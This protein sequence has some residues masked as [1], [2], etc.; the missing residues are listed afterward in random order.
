[1]GNKYLDIRYN[2]GMSKLSK[3][4]PAIAVFVISIIPLV[5]L[6]FSGFPIT[7][8]GQDH[9]A[10]IANFYR[11]LA[12]GNIIPRWASNLNWGY[13]H[14]ILMFLYPFPSYIA[15]FFHFL[16]L[17]FVDS[18]KSVFIVA[19][20]ASG[21][22]MYVWM[23]AVFGK[24]AGI[25]GSILY[26]FAPY[27]FVDLYVRGAIGEHVAFIFPPLI[28]YFLFK[29][30][31]KE[32]NSL[33]GIGLS[34]SL[35]CFILSH[36]A[37]S[38]MFLPVIVL[39]AFYLF[40]T[41][42]KRSMRF[43]LSASYSILLGFGLSAFF[44]FPAFF[45]GKYT[46]RDI[47]TAGEAMQRFVPPMMFFYSPWNYGG[48]NEI[49]KMIGFAQ[50][51]GIIASVGIFIKTRETK[52]KILIGGLFVLFIGS[53]LMMTK[54]SN[55]LWTNITLLQKFQFPWR[56][57]SLSVFLV[58]VLGGVAIAALKMKSK[59]L[60]LVPLGI[61]CIYAVISTAHMWK[62]IGYQNKDESFYTG[63]YLST[64]DTGE[65]SP[66]WSTRFMEHV[67][68]DPLVLIDGSAQIRKTLRTTTVHEYEIIAKKPSR[69]VENTVYFPGWNVYIDERKAEVE[70]QDPNYRGLLTF[71]V[72]EGN[73]AVR[74]QFQD[75][76]LRFI[77]NIISIV[78]LVTL[79]LLRRKV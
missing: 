72:P 69:L 55:V 45:E 74:V 36:N 75:T 15:S 37:I 54:W 14:P 58:A 30:V 27:R 7:H 63:I 79:I 77:S 44:L 64:T 10:R 73:H 76:K 50:W 71:Y 25:I 60:A 23:S 4:V 56:F 17:S 52:K 8:D 29:L 70:F 28:C 2:K 33:A 43:L 3:Y 42:A 9:V 35:A 6:F 61:F 13:G 34:L 32:K 46:L 49:T 21:I 41:E 68:D 16:G 59:I 31:K 66:I 38:I 22:A 12:E 39:Y 19:Y 40:M 51:F 62:P 67:Y 18:T 57:L 65:S 20:I 1:M 53:L 26:L 78:S 24:R 48:G 5:S 11:S 47:V